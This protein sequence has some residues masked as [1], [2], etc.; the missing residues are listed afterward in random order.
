MSVTPGKPDAEKLAGRNLRNLREARHWALREVAERMRDYGYTW[1]QTV[2]SKIETGQRA[3]RLNEAVDLAAM[4]NVNLADLFAPPTGR[5]AVEGLR[6]EAG[7]LQKALGE[8][9]ARE[10]AAQQEFIRMRDE[11]ALARA[12]VASIEG[13]LRLLEGWERQAL[14]DGDA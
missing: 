3:L 5:E 14:G 8:A 10:K 12:E 4:Y 2:I 1:H 6:Q 13:R 9:M 7:A 11:F